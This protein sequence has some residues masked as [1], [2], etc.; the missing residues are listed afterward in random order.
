MAGLV[1]HPAWEII[2]PADRD[3]RDK[4]MTYEKRSHRWA[5][6]AL[7]LDSGRF[8]AIV[9]SA[10]GCQIPLFSQRLVDYGWTPRQAAHTVSRQNLP[11]LDL[12]I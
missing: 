2:H 6:D 9:R 1:G 7:D 10:R 11:A 3:R 4:L 8:S 12:A 5:H